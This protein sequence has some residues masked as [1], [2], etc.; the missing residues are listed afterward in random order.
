MPLTSSRFYPFDDATAK[1]APEKAGAYELL[2]KGTVV[3]IGSS[4][5][6]IRKRIWTHRKNKH[7]MHVTHFRYSK[8]TWE[9]DA[10]KLEASLCKT[11]KKANGDKPRLQQRT[12]VN[13]GIFD[14]P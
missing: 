3:Y 9:E 2:Y 10:I 14:W 6:S 4:K 8:V 12:P 13:R 7:F 1:T 11:F 5:D